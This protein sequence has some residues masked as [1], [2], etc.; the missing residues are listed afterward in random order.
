VA[1]FLCISSEIELAFST[2]IFNVEYWCLA[3]LFQT[4]I[5]WSPV[6]LPHHQL[7]A[8]R[9]DLRYSVSL[10]LVSFL[11]VC[12]LVLLFSVALSGQF[13]VACRVCLRFGKNHHLEIRKFLSLLTSLAQQ[14]LIS[15]IFLSPFDKFLTSV[16]VKCVHSPLQVQYWV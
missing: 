12:L 15:H 3:N 2:H 5:Y 10:L 6:C 8:H 4:G 1:T 13:P 7:R 14:R 9:S 16:L 11:C